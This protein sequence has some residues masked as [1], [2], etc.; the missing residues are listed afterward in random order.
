MLRKQ[1]WFG[2][3]IIAAGIAW[4]TVS[5]VRGLN[6]FSEVYHSAATQRQDVPAAQQDEVIMSVEYGISSIV[7]GLVIGLFGV[8]L[9]VGA[10]RAPEQ[11]AEQ[12]VSA[13]TT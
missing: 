13:A 8:S 10:I 4:P 9:A 2:C 7:G 12:T 11:E 3:V 1:F 6:K 5:I